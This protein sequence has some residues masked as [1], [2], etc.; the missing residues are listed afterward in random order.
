M[1]PEQT[2]FKQLLAFYF[3]TTPTT[4]PLPLTYCPYPILTTS[5]K[6]KSNVGRTSLSTNFVGILNKPQHDQTNKM[7]CE[8]SEDSDQPGYPPGLIRFFAVRV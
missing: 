4:N 8:P 2:C 5:H 3:T 6:K 7:T 1:D